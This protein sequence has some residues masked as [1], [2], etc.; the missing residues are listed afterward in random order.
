[1][2]QIQIMDTGS[3]AQK[4]IQSMSVDSQKGILKNDDCQ[5]ID[6][7][8]LLLQLGFARSRSFKADRC[9]F[10]RANNSATRHL[11][12]NRREGGRHANEV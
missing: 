8:E 3:L 7:K 9:P 1:M 2:Q 10:P 6:P 11:R 4:F 5:A 12:L